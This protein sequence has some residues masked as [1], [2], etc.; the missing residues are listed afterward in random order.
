[1]EDELRQKRFLWGVALAWAPWVPTLIGFGYALRGISNSKA[2]GLAAVAGGFAEGFALWGIGTIV[3]GQF[4]AIIW[5]S[6]SFSREHWMR[7]A[8]SVVSMCLS[9]L[10]LV[11]MCCVLWF[12]WF[13]ARR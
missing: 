1:M 7:N 2:T 8:V 12:A 6:R 4:A 9:G 10:M 11:I 3:I 13:Q 5:L